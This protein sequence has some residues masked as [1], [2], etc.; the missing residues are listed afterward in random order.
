MAN[1]M[2]DLSGNKK[3][4]KKTKKKGEKPG[5]KQNKVKQEADQRDTDR[6]DD[7][8][9]LGLNLDVDP[10]LGYTAWSRM[11]SSE[12]EWSESESGQGSR[13]RSNFTKVRQCALSCFFWITKV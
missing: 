11:S 3:V 12:S 13:S 7:R 8:A 9:S 6:R 5:S 1:N 4:K 10:M 2:L